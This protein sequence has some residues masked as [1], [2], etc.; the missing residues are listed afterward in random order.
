MAQI[1]PFEA[2][3]DYTRLVKAKGAEP[4]RPRAQISLAFSVS[5]AQGSPAASSLGFLETLR[6]LRPR[7]TEF[8]RRRIVQ[9]KAMT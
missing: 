2:G 8:K 3:S 7:V 9:C 1:Q 6:T 5:L 4:A